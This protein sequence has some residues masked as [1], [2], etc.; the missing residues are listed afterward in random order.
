[1]YI[2]LNSYNRI[3]LPPYTSSDIMEQKLLFSISK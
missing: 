3:D 2:N 1:M